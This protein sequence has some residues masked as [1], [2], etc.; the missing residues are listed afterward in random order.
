MTKRARI[1][2]DMILTEEI[3]YAVYCS[4]CKERILPGEEIIE[5]EGRYVHADCADNFVWDLQHTSN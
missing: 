1:E 4:I 5:S 3:N 2:I